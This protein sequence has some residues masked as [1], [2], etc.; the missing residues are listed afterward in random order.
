MDTPLLGVISKGVVG[1]DTMEFREFVTQLTTRFGLVVGPG[2]EEEVVDRIDL[3]G[4][5]GYNAF[6]ILAN[7]QEIFR[8]RL[9]RT[10]LARSYSDSHTEVLGFNV[11]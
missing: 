5:D 8:E 9:L 6:E 10:G 11:S 7:N 1:Q 3:A 2:V 4:S